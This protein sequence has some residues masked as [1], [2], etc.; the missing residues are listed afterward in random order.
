MGSGRNRLSPDRSLSTGAFL[1]VGQV[2]AVQG[3]AG[4]IKVKAISG[5]P[6]GLLAAHSLRLCGKPDRGGPGGRDF[7]VNAAQRSGGCAVFALKGIET[8]EAAGE[9]VGARV[10]VRRE[11]LPPPGEDEYFVADLVG[12]AV[13][14]A[15][16][17]PIGR[18]TSVVSGTAHDWLEIR[19]SGGEEALLPVVSEFVREVDVAGRRIV[20]T[21][22]EGWLDAG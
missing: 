2:V 10:F 4:R 18:V 1:E 9:L 19:R 20:V 21:P 22:P 6:S 14:A 13:I 17:V 12:C 8:P 5:D 7:E 15:D 11:E 3:V 16:G